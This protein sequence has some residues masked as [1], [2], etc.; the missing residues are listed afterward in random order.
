MLGLRRLGARHRRLDYGVNVDLALGSFVDWQILRGVNGG[1]R[2]GSGCLA[3][4]S[5]E[6]KRSINLHVDV[7]RL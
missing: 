5:T 3:I 7:I 2:Y 1:W 4:P 6:D